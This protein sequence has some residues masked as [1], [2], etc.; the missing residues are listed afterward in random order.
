MRCM[1]KTILNETGYLGIKLVGFRYVF[2]ILCEYI[3][4]NPWNFFAK[5][6]SAFGSLKRRWCHALGCL[7]NGPNYTSVVY[8]PCKNTIVGKVKSLSQ[9]Q[10]CRKR[11]GFLL[12]E[13]NASWPTKGSH[14]FSSD[15]GYFILLPE[16]SLFYLYRSIIPAASSRYRQS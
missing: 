6:I 5:R 15:G 14:I 9:S 7:R 11:C 3:P 16:Q 4:Q 13:E 10:F 12:L 8:Q 2:A 1:T